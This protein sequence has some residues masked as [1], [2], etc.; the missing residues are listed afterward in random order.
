MY[1]FEFLIIFIYVRVPDFS[2]NVSHNNL[3]ST[4]AKLLKDLLVHNQ[5]IQTLQ[6]A[7]ITFY[8]FPVRGF[9]FAF[10]D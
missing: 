9:Y 7:G 5:A 10:W 6:A 1:N 8:Y 4:G 2:Q 3:G